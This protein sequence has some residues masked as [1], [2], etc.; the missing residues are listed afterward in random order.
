MNNSNTI[1]VYLLDEG[2]DV[3]RP[4]EAEKLGENRY[5]IIST[6]KD[7]DTEN[8]QFKTGEVVIGEMKYLSGDHGKSKKCIVAVSKIE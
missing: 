4:V 8:W 1:Y 5:R 7:I 2:V 6:N 3:L